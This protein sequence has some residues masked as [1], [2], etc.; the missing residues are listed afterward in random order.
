MPPFVPG[1]HKAVLAWKPE[2]W[3]IPTEADLAL[4]SC[5]ADPLA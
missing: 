3:L 4:E 1:S 5:L 2:W